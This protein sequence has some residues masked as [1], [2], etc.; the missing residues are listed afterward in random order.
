MHT[1]QIKSNEHKVIIHV[2]NEQTCIEENQ[3]FL[4]MLNDDTSIGDS[5][6]L[7]SRPPKKQQQI[8]T[9]T[10]IQ[11]SGEKS[12]LWY[13]SHYYFNR[14]VDAIEMWHFEWDARFQ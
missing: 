12:T 14:I 1:Y 11:Y 2:T 5:M 10:C 3:L 4:L 7:T 6:L 13:H 9:H 8:Y